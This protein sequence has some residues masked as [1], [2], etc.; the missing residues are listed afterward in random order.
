M[1]EIKWILLKIYNSAC[2]Q[3]Y[4][5]LINKALSKYDENEAEFECNG[6]KA[7]RKVFLIGE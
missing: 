3:N 6:G 7:C 1:A 2:Q 5:L 4:A